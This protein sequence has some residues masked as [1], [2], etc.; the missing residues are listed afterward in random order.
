MRR[1]DGPVFGDGVVPVSLPPLVS[2]RLVFSFRLGSVLW[3]PWW[4][5]GSF[6]RLGSLWSGKGSVSRSWLMEACRIRESGDVLPSCFPSNWP[7]TGLDSGMRA[8]CCYL[9]SL[10]EKKHIAS[11]WASGD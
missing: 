4:P 6:P 10:V 1:G 9:S 5:R 11:P 2:D 7:T 8:R 3:R